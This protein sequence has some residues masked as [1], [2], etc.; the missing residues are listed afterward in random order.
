MPR[1]KTTKPRSPAK[2]K[3]SLKA[4]YARLKR[5]FTAADLQKY[6]VIEPMVPAEQVLAK[7][8]EM[9]RQHTLKKK[10]TN[11]RKR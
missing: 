1:A 7:M 5:E 3:E 11:G 4:I 8:K 6:T 2:K 10:A 9:Y